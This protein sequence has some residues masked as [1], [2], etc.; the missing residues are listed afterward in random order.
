MES[1]RA[2][3]LREAIEQA[4][5]NHELR[6]LLREISHSHDDPDCH[7]LTHLIF[8]RRDELKDV[9]TDTG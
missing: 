9:K 5:T 6:R 3:Q 1:E 8:R 4:N 2:R 7:A